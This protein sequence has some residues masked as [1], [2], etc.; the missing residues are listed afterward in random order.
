M[1][2]VRKFI[3]A[4]LLCCAGTVS[5]AAP[6]SLVQAEYAFGRAVK[7]HGL[8]DGFLMYL[9]PNA[10]AFAPQPTAAKAFYASRKPGPSTLSWYPVMARLAGSGDFGFTTGPW[11]VSFTDRDGKPAVV[12][13][14]YVTIWH[15]DAKG[16]WRWLLDTGVTH[17]PPV[18]DAAALPDDGESARYALRH[19]SRDPKAKQADALTDLD[20]RYTALAT[21]DGMREVYARLAADD[22]R[23]LQFDSLPLA[24]RAAV[25]KQTPEDKASLRW[26]TSGSGIATSGDLGYTYGMAYPVDAAQ[27]IAPQS[28]Y[29]HI[30]QHSRKGWRLLLDLENALPPPHGARS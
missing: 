14:D 20:V 5:A 18:A 7:A 28:V 26:I 9:A 15:R 22:I 1:H 3:V 17:A 24:G 29:V 30:W 21:H 4:M 6:Q 27:G 8:R 12:H 13:G 19:G 23:L 10:I 16:S 11:Q 25:L 2:P